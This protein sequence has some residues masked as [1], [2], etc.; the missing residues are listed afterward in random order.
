MPAPARSCSARLIPPS[1]SRRGIRHRTDSTPQRRACAGATAPPWA[2]RVTRRHVRSPK[3]DPR[4][5][6]RPGAAQLLDRLADRSLRVGSRPARY[7]LPCLQPCSTP[8]GQP[9]SRMS[10]EA[11]RGED[12][13]WR[14]RAGWS[15]GTGHHPAGCRVGGGNHQPR[16]SG[17]AA[18]LGLAPS[19]S[20][21]SGT[22]GTECAARVGRAA[23]ADR[24]GRSVSHPA[25]AARRPRRPRALE[26][27]GDQAHA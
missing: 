6:A 9:H 4:R 16:R 18:R 26:C 11:R 7:P 2:G 13:G 21:S 27:G 15:A 10:A 1:H 17:P 14:S 19:R 8:A 20:R 22:S 25:A 24:D 5:Q 3:R 12:G 23:P